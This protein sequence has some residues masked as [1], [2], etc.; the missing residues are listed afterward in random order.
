MFN[1]KKDSHSYLVVKR[2]PEK[3]TVMVFLLLNL[4]PAVEIYLSCIHIQLQL[5]LLTFKAIELKRYDIITDYYFVSLQ[6]CTSSKAQN[7]IEPCHEPLSVFLKK[8]KL[9][10]LNVFISMF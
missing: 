4:S 7:E 9:Q 3:I 5:W 6:I 1:K 8:S 2:N 10:P